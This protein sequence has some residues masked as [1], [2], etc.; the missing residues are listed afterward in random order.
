VLALDK[1]E[2][3]DEIEELGMRL[4]RMCSSLNGGMA[5]RYSG[6]TVCTCSIRVSGGRFSRSKMRVAFLWRSVRHI[7]S[8]PPNSSQHL[9][10]YWKW[11]ITTSHCERGKARDKFSCKLIANG[12]SSMYVRTGYA[13]WSYSNSKA[14]A[15][16]EPLPSSYPLNANARDSFPPPDNQ[17]RPFC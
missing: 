3:A 7:N 14:N 12:S 10:Y 5:A 11:I 8:L 1:G 16:L 15:H 13:C 17:R 4:T 9:R 6:W 2:A